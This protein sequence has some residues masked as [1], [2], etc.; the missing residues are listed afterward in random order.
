[1]AAVNRPRINPSRHFLVEMQ[2]DDISWDEVAA[3]WQHC[4]LDRESRDHPGFRVRTSPT[5]PDGSRVSVV[6]RVHQDG[7][8]LDLITTWRSR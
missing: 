3:A 4:E 2:L 6:G 7:M 8:A 1:M 5:L